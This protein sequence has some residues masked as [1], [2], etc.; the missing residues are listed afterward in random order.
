MVVADEDNGGAADFWNS[1]KFDRA[2][3]STAKGE[4][5]LDFD[6]VRLATQSSTDA[7]LAGF[8]GFGSGGSIS[9]WKDQKLFHWRRV[10][11]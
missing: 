10:L 11:G 5:D 3:I 7:A 6:R 2:E 8:G 9:G 1:S 4:A